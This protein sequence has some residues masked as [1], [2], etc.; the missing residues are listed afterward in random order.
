MEP[1]SPTKHHSFLASAQCALAGLR[2]AYRT[3]RNLRIDTLVTLLVGAAAAFLGLP[4]EHVPTVLLAVGLVA[5]AEL[6]NTAVEATVDLAEPALNPLAGRAK[7]IAAAG[8][9]VAAIAAGATGVAL[10][11]PLVVRA[12]G[13][14]PALSE[15]ELFIGFGFVVAALLFAAWWVANPVDMRI[16]SDESVEP[17]G[18]VGEL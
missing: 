4:R 17:D 14:P 10:F 15:A 2:T 18:E 3:E 13:G 7:D 12:V 6:L 16:A 1:N 11:A 9:M 5:S 8:V